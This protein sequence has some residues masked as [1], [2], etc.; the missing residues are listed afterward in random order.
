MSAVTLSDPRQVPVERVISHSPRG[1]PAEEQYHE[2]PEPDDR[3]AVG[4]PESAGDRGPL[5]VELDRNAPSTDV[6]PAGWERDAGQRLQPAVVPFV[7]VPAARRM[8]VR[9][10]GA[11][12]PRRDRPRVGALVEVVHLGVPVDL[13]ASACE[14]QVRRAAI[15]EHHERV[16]ARGRAAT[17]ARNRRRP[18]PR[19]PPVLCG[20]RRDSW[21][22]PEPPVH[23]P[24]PPR[25]SRAAQCAPTAMPS[26]ARTTARRLDLSRRVVA[27]AAR[28]PWF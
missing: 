19:G 11:G 17:S 1:Q 16:A 26:A 9:R 4:V 2:R 12:Q 23:A 10:G 22:R 5:P 7:V 14:S 28:L 8:P 15:V 24:R 20:S 21:S 13:H 6:G 27:R 3:R 18:W 25:D